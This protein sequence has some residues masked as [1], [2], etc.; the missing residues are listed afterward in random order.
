MAAIEGRVLPENG[1]GSGEHI[2]LHSTAVE[3]EQH[4]ET[5]S[6]KT[7]GPEE[8]SLSSAGKAEG[9]SLASSDSN[10]GSLTGR[11]QQSS[12]PPPLM[13]TKASEEQLSTIYSE[14]S[15]TPTAMARGD[16][17]SAEHIAAAAEFVTTRTPLPELAPV[18]PLSP[19]E[20]HF[21]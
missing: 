11:G 8:R 20:H 21:S 5:M 18:Q 6:G 17:E 9:R 2:S 16:H 15:T 7:L 10:T 3:E 12:R 4:L 13:F 19:I 1:T 14:S